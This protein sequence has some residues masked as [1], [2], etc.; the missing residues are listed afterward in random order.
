MQGRPSPFRDVSALEEGPKQTEQEV[1]ANSVVTVGCVRCAANHPSFATP[2]RVI[3]YRLVFPR[4][5][6]WIHA[7]RS[8]RFVSDPSVVEFY[9]DGDEFC[10]AAIDPLGDHTEWYQVREADLRDMIRGYEPAAADRPRPLR[11]ACGPTDSRA[12]ALQRA[13][14]RRITTGRAADHLE[15]EEAV[16]DVLDRV[17]ARA[18]E[19]TRGSRDTVISRDE[20]EIADRASAVLSRMTSTHATLATIARATGVSTFHLSRIFRKVTGRTLAKHHRH[21]RLLA[22]LTPLGESDTRIGEI[23]TN[24]GFAGHSH[25]TSVFRRVFGMSPSTYR[26]LPTASRRRATEAQS[27]G[28]ARS[29]DTW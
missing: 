6:V 29:S 5:S 12:Y 11:F 18:Y 27:S 20:R 23:A 21:L 19:S 25:Y 17:L 1:F 7:A 2:G 10:R 28:S 15:V 9:N 3:G 8:R 22:S 13:L 14:F 24:H 26:T 4:R 16:F